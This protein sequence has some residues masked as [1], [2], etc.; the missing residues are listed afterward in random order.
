MF[1][2]VNFKKQGHR[3][4]ILKIQYFNAKDAVIN[5]NKNTKNLRLNAASASLEISSL[6]H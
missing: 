2:S 3:A 1:H 6:V 4:L 5:T